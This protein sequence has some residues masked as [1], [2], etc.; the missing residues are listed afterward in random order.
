LAGDQVK[1]VEAFAKKVT[2]TT[3]KSAAGWLP[4]NMNG[5]NAS[6]SECVALE[7][8]KLEIL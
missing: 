1:I 4:S 3:Q 5:N 7:G 8:V 6:P 2:N